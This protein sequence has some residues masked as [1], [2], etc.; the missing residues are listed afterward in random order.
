MS[1]VQKRWAP[2]LL[3]GAG[4]GL[5]GAAKAT[6]IDRGNGLT[7]DDDLN[8]TWLQD[9][10]YAKTSGYDSD[11]RMNWSEAKTWAENL[12]Y[13]GYDDRRLPIAIDTGASGC[14]FSFNGTD[15]GYNVNPNTSE[16]AHLFFVE[17]GNLS[18]YDTSGTVRG[19]SSGVDWGIVNT[20][21]F[22]NLQKSY[23]RK[24][25]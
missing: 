1:R 19:G 24:C 25:G 3:L 22:T 16:L 4:L 2:V 9:A 8:I 14:Q 13:G 17:P 20:G 11:G 10:N 23:A 12:V 18:A 15:C 7:Y 6:L 5:S 21:P